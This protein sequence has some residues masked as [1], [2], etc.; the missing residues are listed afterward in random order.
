MRPSPGRPV[1]ARPSQQPASRATAGRA[2]LARC[3]AYRTCV[4]RTVDI[5]MRR[6]GFRSQSGTRQNRV[7]TWGRRLAEASRSHVRDTLTRYA[8]LGSK[9]RLGEVLDLTA[10]ASIA[11][12]PADLAELTN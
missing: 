7:R 9:T 4:P 1:L 6:Q 10:C 2:F 8:D 11:S 5:V 12:R 3:T